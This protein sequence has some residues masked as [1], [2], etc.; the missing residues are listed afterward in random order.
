MI[1]RICLYKKNNKE[2]LEELKG[3][4]PPLEE[5]GTLPISLAY[6]GFNVVI[7]QTVVVQKGF[8]NANNSS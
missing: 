8:Y 7:F 5:Y 1:N 6:I 2:L 3:F 4:P